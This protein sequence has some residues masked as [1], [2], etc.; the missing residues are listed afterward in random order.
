MAFCIEP[1]VL[2]KVMGAVGAEIRGGCPFDGFGRWPPIIGRPCSPQ[3]AHTD[4]RW[5]SK[6]A[7]IQEKYKEVTLNQSRSP[8]TNRLG[9][10][11]MPGQRFV[12]LGNGSGNVWADW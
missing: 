7:T 6:H 2:E 12:F 1:V 11:T 4:Q 10:H 9:K 8:R 3:T 5:E